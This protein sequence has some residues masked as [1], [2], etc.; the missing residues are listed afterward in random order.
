MKV[1]VD[2][3]VLTLMLHP[4]ARTP[5]HPETKSPIEHCVQR[6]QGLILTV[7]KSGGQIIVPSPCLA[8]VLSSDE[9]SEEYVFQLQ[10]HAAI[11]VAE[12]SARSAVDFGRMMRKAIRAGDKRG[13]QPGPWQH[14]K[15]DR[16]IVSIA[17]SHRV[18]M[19]V[20]CDERQCAFAKEVGLKVVGLHELEIP[21]DLAQR[22][23]LSDC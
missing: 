14:V 19:F 5:L 16:M 9:A 18:D 13:G 4:E 23:L 21:Q 3:T 1:A 10:S 2:N 12:F 20:S 8:E 22:D 17:Q 15:M 11:E 7:N 6:V